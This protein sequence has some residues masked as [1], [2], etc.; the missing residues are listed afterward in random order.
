MA[1]AARPR[2][3]PLSLPQPPALRRPAC[4]VA[5]ISAAALAGD[6]GRREG[7]L[8]GGPRGAGGDPA[9]RRLAAARLGS[10]AGDSDLRATG[11]F[12]SREMPAAPC[13]CKVR[14]RTRGCTGRTAS[15]RPSSP[16]QQEGAV[17]QGPV[18]RQGT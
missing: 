9:A 7:R 11:S 13:A 3:L 1:H 4:R 12:K 5:V 18:H 10:P 16:R 14:R 15:P 17:T 2:P 6:P 8:V